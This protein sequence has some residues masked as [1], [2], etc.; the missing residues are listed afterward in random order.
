MLRQVG[1]TNF[2]RFKQVALPLSQ[3][4]VLM[5][6]NGAGKST[7]IQSLLVTR[8]SLD[9]G[10]LARGYL[11]LA[12]ELAQV[13]IGQDLLFEGAGGE[14]GIGLSFETPEGSVQ[15]LASYEALSDELALSNSIAASQLGSLGATT[16]TYLGAERLGPRLSAPLS[17]AR[18]SAGRL[19]PQ[20]EGTLA[21]L[22]HRRS[23]LLAETDPRVLQGVARSIGEQTQAYLALISP[24][25]RLSVSRND[26]LDSLSA[27]FAF[28]GE[29]GVAT[30]PFR[31]TNVGFGLSYSLPIIVGCL[32]ARPGAILIVENPEAHL[33]TIG[34]RQLGGLLANTAAAGVQVVVETHSRELFYEFR[35]ISRQ[36][37]GPDS[38][39]HYFTS[40]P[41]GNISKLDIRTL[42]PI[43]GELANWPEEFFQAFGRPTDLIAGAR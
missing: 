18:A 12:G 41:Q 23:E 10:A 2:K 14:E 4:T 27:A 3:L 35:E 7:L 24:G 39:L 9:S 11:A 21:V 34:Q 16:F 13:G 20:G 29:G 25:A 43:S 33:H 19:G 8:Q 6:V 30:R 1:L 22:E 38:M 28:S 26:R 17:G 5:G 31:P 32:A 42:Y 15:L 36:G 40:T 37:G